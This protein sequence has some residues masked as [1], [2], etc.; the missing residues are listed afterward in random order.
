L[1]EFLDL[2]QVRV[3]DWGP[4]AQIW[5]TEDGWSADQ[6]LSALTDAHPH[7]RAW[8]KADVPA[9][10]HFHAHKRVPDVIAEADLGWMLSNRPYYAGMELGLLNGMHGW[11]PAWF[12]M[13][14]IF[15]AHGPA[16]A[17]GTRMPSMRGIDLYSLM[18]ELLQIE[19]AQ[20][21][22]SLTA[23]APVLFNPEPAQIRQS[24][25]RCG[26]ERL[27]LREGPA[28]A[29]VQHGQRVFALPRT[30]SASGVKY[31]DTQMLFW[32]KGDEAQAMIDGQRLE[33]CQNNTQRTQVAQR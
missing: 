27:V 21:H 8:K 23:I 19:P 20:T 13:H 30:I 16:F 5:A 29:S 31:E 1:D 18:A 15:V 28:S 4:V 22:G 33:L 26:D 7:M 25:W 32:S 3:S 11:E 6:I 12:N 14:G 10:Y 17:A 9:R 2:S 24:D